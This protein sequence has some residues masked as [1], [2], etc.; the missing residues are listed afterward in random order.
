MGS[1]SIRPLCDRYPVLYHLSH[2]G[3]WP[4]IQRLGL[5]STERLLDVFDVAEPR[6]TDLL[7]RRRP[8]PFPFSTRSTGPP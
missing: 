8:A 2:A 7:T 3:S 4:T 6:R 1:A 5:L